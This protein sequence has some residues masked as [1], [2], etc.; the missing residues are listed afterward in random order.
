M[1]KWS[2]FKLIYRVLTPFDKLCVIVFGCWLLFKQ[3]LGLKS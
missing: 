2:N 3:W 1:R